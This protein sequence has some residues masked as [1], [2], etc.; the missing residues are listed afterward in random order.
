MKDF[1]EKP[2]LG[3]APNTEF[4]DKLCLVEDQH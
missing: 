4:F 1:L 2:G 3:K